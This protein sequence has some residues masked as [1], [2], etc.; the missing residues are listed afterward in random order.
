MSRHRI[1]QD[2]MFI[3][4]DSNEYQVFGNIDDQFVAEYEQDLDFA[5]WSDAFSI[6][7]YKLNKVFNN[8]RI[9]DWDEL[10]LD[11]ELHRNVEIKLKQHFNWQNKFGILIIVKGA[12]TGMVYISRLFN[13][14]HFAV[15]DQQVLIDN[16]FWTASAWFKIPKLDKFENENLL[17]YCD[18]ISY[19]DVIS[20]GE[21]IGLITTYPSTVSAFEPLIDEQVLP[22]TIDIV[23]E[24]QENQYLKILPITQVFGKTVQQSLLE[25]LNLE[26]NRVQIIINHHVR[27]GNID[28]ENTGNGFKTIMVRNSDN[29][30]G[31]VS[32]GIDFREYIDDLNPTKKVLINISTE[33]IVNDIVMRRQ[34]QLIYDFADILNPIVTDI[35]PNDITVFPVNVT[36]TTQMTQ[37]VIETKETV[38]IVKVMQPVVVELQN[39][40]DVKFENKFIS[41]N[42]VNVDSYILIE[43][44]DLTI[45]SNV[46]A[47]NT[48]YFDLNKIAKPEKPVEFVI[49]DQSN[50]GNN[51]KIL[52]KGTINV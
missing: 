50:T 30:F 29:V 48:I 40:P 13:N 52:Q 10:S 51:G 25:Y 15:S 44:L 27:Y 6:F 2:V 46:A 23:A 39:N 18:Y 8:P 4:N 26:D 31:E 36:E 5:V 12:T 49:V 37:N 33:F 32:F 35:L 22:P 28:E 14:T 7:S 3:V 9:F 19:D 20:S 17:V 16:S 38:K 45:S 42:N 24:L 1:N 43:S 41:F 11:S 21:D 34:K 47:D